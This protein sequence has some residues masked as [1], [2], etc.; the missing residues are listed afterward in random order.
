MENNISQEQVEQANVSNKGTND[1]QSLDN[2]S[3]TQQNNLNDEKTFQSRYDK[4][5]AQHQNILK[6]MNSLSEKAKLLEEISS[7]PEYLEAFVREVN[8]NLLP[9]KDITLVIQD[10]LHAEFGDYKPSRM[11]ADEEPGGK[12]WLYFKRLDELYNETK[13][14]T[15]PLKKV[16]E[17]KGE[18]QQAIES[19][20]RELQTEFKLNDNSVTGFKQWANGLNL[21][22][23]YQIYAQSLKTISSPDS[24]SINGSTRPPITAR[25]Q[26]LKTL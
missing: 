3:I 26:F 20:I 25:D 18:K 1:T 12:A 24:I 10:K 6:E 22:N 9:Q 23:L 15:K 2:G 21:K 7:D 19:Q 17:I 13:A 5:Y 14:T 4:L 11:E 16:S 8:P